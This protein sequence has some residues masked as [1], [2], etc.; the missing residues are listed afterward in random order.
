MKILIFQYFSFHPACKVSTVFI[1]IESTQ[2]W[3]KNKYPESQDAKINKNSAHVVNTSIC[4]DTSIVSQESSSSGVE[5]KVQTIVFSTIYK[6]AKIFV[7]AMFMPY[8]EGP[9][10]DWTVNDTLYHRFLNW[11]LKCENILDCKLAMLPDSKKCKKVIAWSGD[12]GMDQYVSW[13]LPPEDL[14]LVVIWVTFE[15]FCKSQTNEVRA[16]FDLLTSFM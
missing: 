3:P 16:R 8:I 6:S 14:S 4:Q 7:Q 12:F 15:D 2:K 10:M 5:M 9:K 11:K 13:C 1:I